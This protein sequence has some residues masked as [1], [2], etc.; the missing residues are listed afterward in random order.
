MK[1]CV[2]AASP[3]GPART[4]RV[5]SP[6]GLYAAPPGSGVRRSGTVYLCY[7]CYASM[8]G[9]LPLGGSPISSD[10]IGTD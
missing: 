7:L 5:R 8:R 1:S 2:N 4:A 9:A 3:P 10:P 6:G